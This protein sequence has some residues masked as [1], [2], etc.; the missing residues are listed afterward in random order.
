MDNNGFIGAVDFMLDI[1]EQFSFE[2]LHFSLRCIVKSFI[3]GVSSPNDNPTIF[4]T[5]KDAFLK[6]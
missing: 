4:V 1:Q 6:V 3:F 5:K 2:W